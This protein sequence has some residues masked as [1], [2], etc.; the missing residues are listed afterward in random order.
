MPGGAVTSPSAGRRLALAPPLRSS[1]GI[2]SPPPSTSNLRISLRTLPPFNSH[3][4]LTSC[5]C[6]NNIRCPSCISLFSLSFPSSPRQHWQ[7]QHPPPVIS[8]SPS[9]PR[10]SSPT[11]ISSQPILT[12]RSQP[13][14]RT[15]TTITTSL[16]PS[17]APQPSTSTISPPPRSLNPTS[18]TSAHR[19]MFSLR[20]A[21][22][23]LPMA[24]SWVSGRPFAATPG[25][26]AARRSSSLMRVLP[27][28]VTVELKKL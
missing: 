13:S 21:S 24:L 11:R 12:R 23:S 28:V 8:P 2:A 14:Q 10:P 9:P 26:I 4:T 27:A 3:T 15:Q 16:H 19:S 5:T 6:Q 22:T 18:S 7:P 20:S 25:I 1:I 17:P